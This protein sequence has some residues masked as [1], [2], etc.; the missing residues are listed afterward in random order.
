MAFQHFMIYWQSLAFPG[1]WVR[2][3]ASVFHHHMPLSVFL[4]S[5]DFLLMASAV[6]LDW[7]PTPGCY[8]LINRILHDPIC[9]EAQGCGLS[10]FFKGLY[11]ARLVLIVMVVRALKDEAE[12]QAI[13][14]PSPL[15]SSFLFTK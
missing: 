1:L 12:R 5:P 15:F 2:S 3:V 8:I 13:S 6:I 9:K 14:G 7:R 10:V 11:V 4:C